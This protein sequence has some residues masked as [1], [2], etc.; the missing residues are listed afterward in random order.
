MKYLKTNDEKCKGCND[1]MA[2]C[3]TLYFKVNSPEKSRISVER[4]QANGFHLNVCNQCGICVSECPVTALTINKTGVIMLNAK[5]CIGCLA[6]VAVCPSGS[7]RHAQ[8]A[9]VPIKCVACG[10]CAQK[11][12]E[13]ALEICVEGN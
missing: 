7:M 6:C 4:T 11:C 3:S 1:C 8:G 9:L 2:A 10:A 12:P 5:L 13:G